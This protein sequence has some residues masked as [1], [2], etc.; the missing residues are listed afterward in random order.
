[1]VLASVDDSRSSRDGWKLISD[2][3]RAQW[4]G[5]TAGVVVGLLWTVGK[6]A[7]PLLVRT[8]IDQGIVADD[9]QALV[10]W[11]LAIVLAGVVAATFTGL[12]R[13]LAFRE[14]R[15][16]E[17]V[18]RDRMF[19]HL[20]RL[21]FAFHDEN[22]TGELMS[23]ANTDLQQVQQ[24]VVLIPLTI[25]NAVTVGSV[26]IILALIDPVLT[27]LALGGLPFLN[28][29]GKRFS[30]RLHV[31]AM[32]IQRESA[33]LAS[34]VE[35][36]GLGRPRGEG[37]RRRT[38]PGR[39][40]PARGRRRLPGVDGGGPGPCRLP[41]RHRVAAQHRPRRRPRV[42]RPPGARRQP[43]PRVASWPSTS[44]SCC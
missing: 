44:T 43:Q 21:H 16:A 27:V 23:R 20:Q 35:E 30:T 40:P 19:A 15:W 3:M 32:A 12:R 25:S 34:V 31:P 33:E 29:L 24:F 37:L 13:Y 5:I 41:A 8:A 39:P 42:R 14:S 28:L 6:V 4:K 17:L 2:T 7:T 22:Q 1:M 10:F 11:S 36:I 26:A 9:S 18:L 38:G